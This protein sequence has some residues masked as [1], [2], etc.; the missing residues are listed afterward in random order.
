[1]EDEGPVVACY[2]PRDGMVYVIQ[3]VGL[4]GPN[5]LSGIARPSPLNVKSVR[6][7]INT[8]RG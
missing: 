3:R 7:V 5:G 8:D 2:A 4:P 6:S 1:M